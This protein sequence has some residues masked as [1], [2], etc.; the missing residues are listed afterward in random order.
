[1][2]RVNL[3]EQGVDGNIVYV[4][5][6]DGKTSEKT[7]GIASLEVVPNTDIPLSSEIFFCLVAQGEAKV[8]EIANTLDS[9][10]ILFGVKTPNEE[11]R[12]LL[13]AQ[14]GYSLNTAQPEFIDK[15]IGK[16]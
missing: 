11:I 5:I 14:H 12:Q 16:K 8:Q 4:L 7:G 13:L 3:I 10:N 6:N 9:G 2:P 1:M 15:E